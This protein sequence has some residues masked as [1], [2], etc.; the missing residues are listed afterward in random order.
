M[1]VLSDDLVGFAALRPMVDLLAGE[2]TEAR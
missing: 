1:T 2:L